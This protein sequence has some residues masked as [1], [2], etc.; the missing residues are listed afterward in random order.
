MRLNRR[1]AHVS[2]EPGGPLHV[3]RAESLDALSLVVDQGQ[4]WQVDTPEFLRQLPS[5]ARAEFESLAQAE[6]ALRRCHEFLRGHLALA[7]QV[8]QPLMSIS[9]AVSAAYQSFLEG[10]PVKGMKLALSDLTGE[11]G[12]RDLVMRGGHLKGALNVAW[13]AQLDNR[14]KQWRPFSLRMSDC[15][16]QRG[17]MQACAGIAARIRTDAPRPMVTVR[18]S[19]WVAAWHPIGGASWT[20]QIWPDTYLRSPWRRQLCDVI[21][22]CNAHYRPVLLDQLA[23]L[24]PEVSGDAGSPLGAFVAWAERALRRTEEDPMACV[25]QVGALTGHV[26]H[27]HSGRMGAGTRI[28]VLHQSDLDVRTQRLRMAQPLGWLLLTVDEVMDLLSDR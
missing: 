1:L 2:L 5:E 22:C 24:A 4:I 17:A 11:R 3:G 10:G 25:L 19:E 9:P 14:G 12:G 15:H 8:G 28:P 27:P 6:D 13:R 18:H 23:K 26:A 20:G 16:L 7:L 21:L